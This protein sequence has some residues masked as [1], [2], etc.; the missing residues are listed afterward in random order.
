MRPTLFLHIGG[1]KTGTSAIQSMLAKNTAVLA[2]LGIH[3][4]DHHSLAAARELQITSGNGVPLAKL[5]GCRLPDDVS[6][7]HII[8]EVNGAFDRGTSLLYSSE[9]LSS[10]EIEA[11]KAFREQVLEI[12]FRIKVIFYVRSVADHAL[13]LWN[14]EVKSALTDLSFASWIT[15][16]YAAEYQAHPLRKAL[17]VYGENEIDVRNYD[18]ASDLFSDFLTAL[19]VLDLHGFDFDVGK[20]NRSLNEIELA[21]MRAMAP[22]LSDPGQARVASDAIIG[23]RP[24]VPSVRTISQDAMRAIE[25]SD[26]GAVEFINAHLRQKPI[27]LISDKLSV[28]EAPEPQLSETEQV[29]AAAIAGI[30][31]YG[32]INITL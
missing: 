10:F 17:Q 30:I 2:G 22:V 31:R 26:D 9:A 7:D 13:S 11:A 3:Y 16:H 8:P 32:R 20:V 6:T 24:Q 19:D 23:Q 14:Q 12:G 4:P 28:T 21:V 29:L 18:C 27:G 25:A 1:P 5:L 15:P